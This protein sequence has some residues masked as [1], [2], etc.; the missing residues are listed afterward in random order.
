MGILSVFARHKI[1][2][3][4]IYKQSSYNLTLD[5][6]KE[7]ESKKKKYKTKTHYPS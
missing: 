1:P 5:Y 2:Y 6:S 3:Y 4:D 7:T